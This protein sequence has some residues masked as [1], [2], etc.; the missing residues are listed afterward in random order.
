VNEK[1]IVTDSTA[2]LSDQSRRE[3]GIS[4]VPLYVQV[5]ESTFK[6]G[7][8]LS[9][10]RF[11]KLL[12]GEV[13]P[14]TSAP[15]PSEFAQIYQKLARKAQEIIS[16]HISAKASATCQAAALAAQSLEKVKV[17]VYDSGGVSMGI[18][19]LAIEASRAAMQ[20][21]STKE[22]LAKLDSLKRRLHTYVAIPT[23]KY[24]Q[25]SG[26]VTKGQALLGSLLSIKPVLEIKDGV[27]QI[28]DRLRTFPKA[29]SRLID[30]AH[31]TAGRKPT[32]MAVMHAN[33]REEAEKFAARLRDNL[34]I[35]ELRIGEVGPA[36]AAHGGPGMI[37]IV[38]YT[39]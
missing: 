27:V 34:N 36:L 13:M 38:F 9:L 21:L 33:A 32:I 18:G 20:G 39:L 4:V 2:D 11:Y 15:P 7:E 29:L 14:T 17:T 26:R 3:Y 1:A 31:E 23:L 6:D 19:F 24:L 37:G 16:I 8:D 5:G 30:M 22:I 10:E 35:S 28:V 25:K 12:E